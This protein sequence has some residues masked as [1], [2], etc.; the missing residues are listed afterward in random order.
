[1]NE[2]VKNG[3]FEIL[4]KRDLKITKE[5]FELLEE[6]NQ[7]DEQSS[8]ET[9]SLERVM[10]FNKNLESLG[11]SLGKDTIQLM[12]QSKVDSVATIEDKLIEILSDMSGVQIEKARIFYPN[13]PEQVMEMEESELYFNAIIHYLSNGKLFPVYNKQERLLVTTDFCNLK[14]ISL[15]SISDLDKSFKS[16][17]YSPIAVNDFDMELVTWYINF[18][19]HIKDLM[20]E[21]IP[22]KENKSKITNY[23]LEYRPQLVSCLYSSYKSPTDVL[24]LAVAMSG[25]DVTLTSK[26]QFRCFKRK[27]KR[28]FISLLNNCGNLKEDMFKKRSEWL[29]FGKYLSVNQFKSYP[30]VIS[31]FNDLRTN[32]KPISFYSRVEKA[33]TLGDLNTIASILKERPGEF[34]RSLNRLIVFAE[35]SEKQLEMAKIYGEVVYLVSTNVLWSVISFFKDRD[36]NEERTFILKGIAS[37]SFTVRNNQL[38]INKHISE[39]IIKTSMRG[40]IHHY[41]KRETIGKVYIDPLM[42]NYKMPMVM[43]NLSENLVP[44][45]TGTKIKFNSN[46]PVLRL[47][48]YWKDSDFFSIDID[49]SLLALTEDFNELGQCAYYRPKNSSLGIFHSGDVRSGGSGASEYIDIDTNLCKKVGV[50]YLV[51][52]VHSFNSQSFCE[53]PDCFCGI[54]ERKDVTKNG[55]LAALF[56]PSTVVNKINLTSSA[57]QTIPLVFDLKNQEYIWLDMPTYTNHDN[58]AINLES[59]T[60]NIINSVKGILNKT[61]PSIKEVVELN[62]RARMGKLVENINEADFIVGNFE[63]AHLTPNQLNELATNWL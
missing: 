43:R 9:V 1:M 31:A 54:M 53:V 58:Y 6:K 56:D 50:R 21:D 40:L 45:A 57:I 16:I 23:I 7:I 33:F 35:N 3:F 20:N 41:S 22:N 5:S 2:N 59:N 15:G 34:A 55:K 46:L 13:F 30:K 25:G 8:V 14:I 63:N 18:A 29:I 11:F 24:R 62:V 26:P 10:S 19:A 52:T 27:E 17:L 49:L 32:N 44:L 47:F 37:K 28:F 38:P 60:D 48:T 12:L 36:N 39:Y 42:E 51:M 61:I 4:L